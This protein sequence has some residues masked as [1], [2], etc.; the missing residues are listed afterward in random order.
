MILNMRTP[1][2]VQLSQHSWGGNIK[3]YIFLIIFAY[4]ALNL[5]SF[6]VTFNYTAFNL[7]KQPSNNQKTEFFE[8]FT[9][10]SK[11]LGKHVR[12]ARAT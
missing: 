12:A 6:M 5:A 7:G 3:C 9:Y 10:I 4:I 8:Q 11:L 1:V 2:R